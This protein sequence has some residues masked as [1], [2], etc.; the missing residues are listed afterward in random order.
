MKIKRYDEFLLEYNNSLKSEEDLAEKYEVKDFK[1]N[2]IDTMDENEITFIG[3][4]YVHDLS[5]LT[6]DFNK[7]SLEVK[8]VDE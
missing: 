5:Y 4:N 6:I 1:I 2:G 3:F 8:S 7:K